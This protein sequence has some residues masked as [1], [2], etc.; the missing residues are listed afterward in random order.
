MKMTII[1]MFMLSSTLFLMMKHPLSSGFMLLMQTTF[2]CMINSMN[3]YS[4]WFS[5]ILFIIFIGGMMV[6]FIYIASIASNEKFKFSMKTMMLM[7]MIT[8]IMMMID[9]TIMNNMMNE[10]MLYIKNTKMS[11]KE[12]MSIMKMFNFPM[13]MLSMLTIIYLLLTLIA[14]VKI[15]MIEKGPLRMKN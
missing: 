4:Y 8:I 12:M 9:S 7:T 14:V 11:N 6:L 10:M 1:M 5:Y 15:T 13:M 2:S 3:S